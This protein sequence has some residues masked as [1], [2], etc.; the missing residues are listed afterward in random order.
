MCARPPLVPP[1]PGVSSFIEANVRTYVVGPDG[2]DGLWFFTLETNSLS[3][4]IAANA[5]LGIP[6]RWAAVQAVRTPRRL[7]YHTRR[8]LADPAPEQTVSI[9]MGGP[10]PPA[11]VDLAAWLTGGG[12]HGR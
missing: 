6:Y 10:I 12:G 2:C 5:A 4:T 1:I 9:A 8:L 3:T 11:D 7:T